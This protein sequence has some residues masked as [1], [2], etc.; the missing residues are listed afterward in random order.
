LS[1]NEFSTKLLKH[2]RKLSVYIKIKTQMSKS[3][4]SIALSIVL[5]IFLFRKKLLLYRTSN[6][7]NDKTIEIMKSAKS[8][9][10]KET[11]QEPKKSLKRLY[12]SLE[13]DDHRKL[14]T[15]KEFN[16]LFSEYSLRIPM[17]KLIEYLGS[18]LEKELKDY[19]SIDL[20]DVITQRI[21]KFNNLLHSSISTYPSLLKED[22][23]SWFKGIPI[24]RFIRYS[25]LDF[26]ATFIKET[27][28]DM[29]YRN[30]FLRSLLSRIENEKELNLNLHK[31]I[32]D[33]SKFIYVFERIE[34]RMDKILHS[35]KSCSCFTAYIYTTLINEYLAYLKS[36]KIIIIKGNPPIIDPPDPDNPE[37]I[38][39]DHEDDITSG[40]D[41]KDFIKIIINKYK[42]DIDISK[43]INKITLF[44]VLF[45]RL[46]DPPHKKLI[47]WSEKMHYPKP[48]VKKT[49]SKKNE[50]DDDSKFTTAVNHNLFLLNHINDNLGTL[51][52]INKRK[53]G[54]YCKEFI[55]LPAYSKDKKAMEQYI[56]DATESNL[57]F[58]EE[59]EMKVGNLY[60]HKEYDDLNSIF[61]NT[62]VKDMLLASFLL[63]YKSP[64]KDQ[65]SKWNNQ[66]KKKL[67]ENLVFK[68]TN[69]KVKRSNR[70][71]KQK[72]K[73][74]S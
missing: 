46:N 40:I 7:I 62:F 34:P 70:E 49:K 1:E 48:K 50:N 64:L 24:D 23:H 32:K 28:K 20:E 65:I 12:L 27:P 47:F 15:Q 30:W 14:I 53:F 16:D 39:I 60:W 35:Y 54:F 74:K 3:K 18:A 72:I 31:K 57:I 73:D 2:A 66:T 26:L 69:E 37:K 19:Y 43:L 13:N 58:E 68:E 25:S 56:E 5:I 41:Q 52:K 44:Q 10:Q 67:Q 8:N 9:E 59:L 71:K 55:T 33:S 29:G 61:K 38:L 42:K 17:F 36:E 21:N 6:R 4:P 22:F 45:N 63:K 11:K 51:W